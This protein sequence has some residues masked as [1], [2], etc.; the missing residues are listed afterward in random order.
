[1]PRTGHRR[2]SAGG[3][4]SERLEREDGMVTVV[5][6]RIAAAKTEDPNAERRRQWLERVDKEI[7]AAGQTE[8]HHAPGTLAKHLDHMVEMAQVSEILE[9]R[10]KVDIR[11][12]VRLTKLTLY[13][14]YVDH[15]LDRAIEATRDTSRQLEKNEILKQ[16][17]DAF[18]I[19]IRLG[20][21]E[22][23]RDSI[24]Q[25]LD[26]I[27]ETSA[28]G[29]SV[30]AKEAA[31]REAKR[32]ELSHPKE[33][34][35]F[36]RWRDPPLIVI[37][38]GRTFTTENWSLG[39]LLIDQFD[40]APRRPGEQLEIKIGIKPERLYKERIEVVR[41]SAEARQLA[42]KSRRFASV[43]MQIKRDCD[44]EELSPV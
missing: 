44:N 22:A 7:A 27:R 6:S 17:N 4:G 24:K 11:D 3:L 12:R 2:G 25:R 41:Y 39:G 34:R 1:V 37:V 43:L 21:S 13:E 10:D 5:R 15:L 26:I 23:I 28:A 33:Q 18:T 31:E 42:V 19:T 30:K 9:A 38:N 36:T 29:E 8:A 20:A 16:V 14:R 40:D 35:T 32:R